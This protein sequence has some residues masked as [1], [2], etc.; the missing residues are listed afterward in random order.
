MNVPT[1]PSRDP[2][3]DATT[4]HEVDAFS[5]FDDRP[6]TDAETW[7]ADALDGVALDAAPDGAGEQLDAMR[8]VVAGIG[9][10]PALDE[11]TRARLV[12]Q[13]L[14]AT[15]E[16]ATGTEAAPPG[17][18]HPLGDLIA[19]RDRSRLQ[20]W[21]APVG[22]AAASIAIVAGLL[23]ANNG[24]PVRPTANPK[25][26]MIESADLDASTTEGAPAN[27]ADFGE[28]ADPAELRRQLSAFTAASNDAGTTP[29]ES[30]DPETGATGRNDAN[31]PGSSRVSSVEPDTTPG[32]GVVLSGGAL[33]PDPCLAS[34]NPGGVTPVMVAIA[35]YEAETVAVAIA[36]EPNRA[37]VF[38]VSSD[39]RIV[40]NQQLATD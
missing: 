22:A 27:I 36:N 23:A 26:A 33:L 6:P 20:R 12:R 28:I 35:T 8:A 10:V 21:I 29:Q 39:C 19:R 37:L 11:V 40:A 4:P 34:L 17:V 9:S 18:D 1:D 7:C 24:D 5:R 32:G 14:A 38:V 15:S 2:S 13:A 30:G 25:D 16:R 3:A 31:P